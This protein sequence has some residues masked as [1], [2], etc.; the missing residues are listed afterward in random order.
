MIEAGIYELREQHVSGDLAAIAG[1]VY[2]AMEYERLERSGLVDQ[3][4]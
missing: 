4:L 3:R 2:Y 1:A